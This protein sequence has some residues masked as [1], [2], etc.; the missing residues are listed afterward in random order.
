MM[1]EGGEEAEVPTYSRPPR[2]G[3]HRVITSAAFTAI[4]AFTPA[5]AAFASLRRLCRLRPFVA[6]SSLLPFLPTYT[7][8]L[9]PASPPV[10]SSLKGLAASP[11]E[12]PAKALPSQCPP[13]FFHGPPQRHSL[14][15]LK[16]PLKH[17]LPLL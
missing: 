14:L 7:T 8:P 12:V 15:P 4:H 16:P 11:D 9:R 10:L 1:T 5:T 3:F 17:S 2:T 13:N 6:S